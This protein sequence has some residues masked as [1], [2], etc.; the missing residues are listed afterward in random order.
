MGDEHNQHTYFAPPGRDDAAD[1]QRQVAFCLDH[2]I[3][4]T[5]LE[6]VNSFAIVLNRKRQ[7][8]SCNQS[9]LKALQLDTPENITGLRPGEA[10][11][12]VHFTRGPDGCGT[13]PHCRT[14]GAVIAILAS[15]ETSEPITEECTLTMEHNGKLEP[16]EFKVK[17]TPLDLDGEPGTI[18]V[19]QDISDSKRK[20]LMEQVFFHDILNTIGGIQ[21]WSTFLEQ[22]SSEPSAREIITLAERLKEEVYAQ[23]TLMEAE[24]GELV[25]NMQTVWLSDILDDMSVLF[26]LHS[27]SHERT[28]K[29]AGNPG[30]TSIYTDRTLVN[31][32][33]INMIKNAFEATGPSG[34]VTVDCICTDSHITFMIHNPGEIPD[35]VR[36]RIF[37]RSFSTKGQ[38]RGIGTWSMKL[39]GEQYLGG[40]V[41]FDTGKHVGTTFKLEL[42]VKGQDL[43]AAPP[44][45]VSPERNAAT[46]GVPDLGSG[47]ILIVD[48]NEPVLRLTELFLKQY[49]ARPL[50]FSD[51]STALREFKNG[52]DNI[53]AALIDIELPVM[54]G[55]MLARKVLEIRPGLPIALMTGY[56]ENAHK[57]EVKE[58]GV[59]QLIKPFNRKRLYETVDLL[60]GKSE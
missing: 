2:P 28:L 47:H 29:L 54:S 33:L 18:L 56:S 23:R 51:P 21:G 10:F 45:P 19:M 49:G 4:R 31:R 6:M 12:C 41:T 46:T 27:V 9:V 37:E 48:D 20:Q 36:E 39:L 26:R 58:L 52:A 60:L 57:G 1:I 22:S 38:G 50:T 34:T 8:V 17:A 44:E 25:M 16:C 13:S 42:P 40:K 43:P 35:D 53:I 7:V 15:M 5:I 3:T 55:L 59:R 32:I 14:C 24:S 11:G 30:T